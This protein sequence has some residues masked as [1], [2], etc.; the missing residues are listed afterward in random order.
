MVAVKRNKKNWVRENVGTWLQ[1]LNPRHFIVCFDLLRQTMIK[2][3]I[4]GADLQFKKLVSLRTGGC[5][6]ITPIED[7]LKGNNSLFSKWN[8]TFERV[9]IYKW[10]IIV[11]S[12]VI[13][14]Q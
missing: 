4:V 8:I 3:T 2:S 6:V 7:T 14:K 1:F 13:C 11:E 10:S 12:V 9:V 5:S